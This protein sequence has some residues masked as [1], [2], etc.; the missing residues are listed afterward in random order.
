MEIL[1]FGKPKG[2]KYQF[3][4]GDV[5]HY[6]GESKSITDK[7][8]NKLLVV[9]KRTISKGQNIYG[10]SVGGSTKATINFS[11]NVLKTASKEQISKASVASLGKLKP[12]TKI[13]DVDK[14]AKK[15]QEQSGLKE[16]VVVEQK[17]YNLSRK[18]AKALAFKQLSDKK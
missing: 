1:G 13:Q 2:H 3:N 10:C 18:Q 8:K 9:R 11:E 5:V 6:K 16:V 4:E 12:L 7:Y 14:L 15:I 17:H